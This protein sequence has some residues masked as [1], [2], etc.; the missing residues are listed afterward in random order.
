MQEIRHRLVRQYIEE[1]ATVPGIDVPSHDPDSSWHLF[2]IRV[3]RHNELALHL[4][5]RGISTGVHYKPIHLYPL[6]HKYDLPIAEAEWPRLLT[7]PLFPALASEQ[8]SE[9]CDAIREFVQAA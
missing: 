1:L 4:R 3:Q 7:L 5:D 2:V 6:Y 9:I 8:V